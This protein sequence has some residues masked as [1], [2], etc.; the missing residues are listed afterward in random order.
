MKVKLMNDIYALE[1]EDFATHFHPTDQFS[2][3]VHSKFD[4]GISASL[5]LEVNVAPKHAINLEGRF[6]YGLNDIFRNHK[7]DPFQGSSS[8]SIMVTLGYNIRVK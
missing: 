7:S 3:P 2:L 5:G 1:N 4:Y 8:M 6:Y